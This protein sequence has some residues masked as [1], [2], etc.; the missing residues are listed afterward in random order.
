M[1]SI[2]I[3]FAAALAEVAGC[4]A[5]WSHFR[6]H[7]SALWLLPGLGSLVL[8]ACL[9]TLV[10]SNAAGRAY[11]TYGGIYICSSLLWLWRVEG[12]RPDLWD[13]TGACLSLIGAGI[14]LFAPR[15]V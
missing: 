6:L 9:L 3:F 14:I 8:F 2:V 15:G 11:A 12:V 10:D 13:V 4:F 1:L 7:K 5:F